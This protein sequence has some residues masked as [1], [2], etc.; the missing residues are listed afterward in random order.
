MSLAWEKSY[1]WIGGAVV[2]V[3]TGLAA[4]RWGVPSNATPLLNSFVS[5]S[6]ILVGF[7]ATAKTILLAIEE[8][9][10]IQ[11]MKTQGYYGLFVTYLVQ[12]TYSALLL[13]LLSSVGALFDFK[14][15]DH[16]HRA[17]FAVWAGNVT[18]AGL[19]L[20]RVLRVLSVFLHTSSEAS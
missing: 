6:G 14:N 18:H 13:A 8:K 11:Q 20:N 10:I 17:F 4:C 1:P 5:T 16:L 7:L 15:Q 12:A 19:A 3:G 9:R 2:L